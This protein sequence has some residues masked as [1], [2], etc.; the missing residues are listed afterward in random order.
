MYPIRL[1]PCWSRW[2]F[3]ETG[4]ATMA[5]FLAAH[6]DTTIEITPTQWLSWTMDPISPWFED[7]GINLDDFEGRLDERPRFGRRVGQAAVNHDCPL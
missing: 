1:C 5:R 6:E 2:L 7:N 4:L 3:A